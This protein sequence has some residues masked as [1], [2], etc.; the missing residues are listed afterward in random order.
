MTRNHEQLL[1]R[2]WLLQACQRQQ[3]INR[4]FSTS[5]NATEK[6]SAAKNIHP[7]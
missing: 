7:I 3:P 2:H 5:A 6:I 1:S 4:F